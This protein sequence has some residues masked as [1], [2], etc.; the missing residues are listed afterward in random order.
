MVLAQIGANFSFIVL[1]GKTGSGKTSVLHQ[2]KQ[3]GEQVIDLEGLANHKGSAFG[4]LGQAPQP[5]TEHFENLLAEE[6]KLFDVTKHVWLEDESKTIGKVFLDV[7]LWNN[8]RHSPVFVIDLPLE[9]R[10][11][12]LVADYGENHLEGLEQSLTNIQR[13]L[14]N[15]QWKKAIEALREKDFKRV[16]NIALDYYDKAYDKGLSLKDTKEIYRFSFEDDNIELMA[17]T[18]LESAKK[19]YGH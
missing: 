1:G 9:A 14:G 18:L 12:R 13:R 11:K 8:I 17:K 15:E 4:S 2:L 5:S 10:L 7:N 3:R 6:L 19:K 16:A